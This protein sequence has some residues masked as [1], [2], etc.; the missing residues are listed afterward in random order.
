MALPG[1]RPEQFAQ[2]IVTAC[3]SLAEPEI[4][5][6]VG[7]TTARNTQLCALCLLHCGPFAPPR[8]FPVLGAGWWPPGPSRR[9]RPC[10]GS[11][12]CWSPPRPMLWTRRAREGRSGRGCTPKR[13][14]RCGSAAQ[15]HAGRSS[16]LF[17]A[18]V[19]K[20]QE[21]PRPEWRSEELCVTNYQSWAV[22][23]HLVDSEQP[24]GWGGTMKVA[25]CNMDLS[26]ERAEQ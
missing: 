22:V 8:R 1:W 26:S 16:H 7:G 14:L 25:A 19:C 4:L 18:R 23:T 20:P 5:G 11:S 12:R 13:T 24:V 10:T 21:A 17:C 15:V 6:Q 3:R 2:G 9:A